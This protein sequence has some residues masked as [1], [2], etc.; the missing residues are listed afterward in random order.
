MATDP[1]ADLDATT[2]DVSTRLHVLHGLTLDENADAEHSE[3]LRAA[4]K[5]GTYNIT[6]L[7]DAFCPVRRDG[8]ID[9]LH[10]ESVFVT[11]HLEMYVNSLF[12]R[13]LYHKYLR[14]LDVA[15]RL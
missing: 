11:M 7:D 5:S 8:T 13:L 3:A 2:A 15:I 9:W 10:L 14:F 1:I 12:S 4:A 6:T